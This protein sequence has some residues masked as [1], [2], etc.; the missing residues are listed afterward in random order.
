M[1]HDSRVIIIGGSKEHA[2]DNAIRE[3]R[4][5]SGTPEIDVIGTLEFKFQFGRC[6]NYNGTSY[7]CFDSNDHDL[8]RTTTDLNSFSA[9][10]RT[11]GDHFGGD[12]VIHGGVPVG[13]GGTFNMDG[14]V[15]VLS[16][17]RW[18]SDA[19]GALGSQLTLFSVLSIDD[20]IY[21]F[22]GLIWRSKRASP[23]GH[24]E[25]LG[26]KGT[27][28]R[29]S[30]DVWRYKNSS[31]SKL[32][33]EY[34]LRGAKYLH[35]TIRWNDDVIHVGGCMTIQS[36]REITYPDDCAVRYVSNSR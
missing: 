30:T 26:V 6:L 14:S 1:I 10:A 19:V 21:V 12:V 5:R 3:I 15:E 24:V 27:S 2:S 18:N 34:R 31:W 36:R 16:G 7:V 28:W 20:S 11:D 29:P 4:S 35:R 17:G 13:I 32:G 8:C 9:I 25:D 33:D 23:D 22:G